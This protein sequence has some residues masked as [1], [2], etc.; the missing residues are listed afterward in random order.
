M[1]IMFLADGYHGIISRLL[2]ESSGI[3]YFAHMLSPNP[4]LINRD[5]DEEVWEGIRKVY[6]QGILERCHLACITSLARADRW[7]QSVRVEMASGNVLGFSAALRGFLE[8]AAD[9]HDVMKI[10]PT[11]IHKLFPYLYLVFS[12]SVEVKNI[13]LLMGELEDGLIHYAYARRLHKGEEHLPHHGHKSNADYIEKFET[14]GVPGAK[15]LYAELCELTHPASSSVSCFYRESEDSIV[16]DFNR[17][18]EIIKGILTR[19]DET[20]ERLVQFSINPALI[21]LSYLHRLFDEWPGPADEEV[22]RL[23]T[24][25][26]RLSEID[27]FVSAYKLGQVDHVMLQKALT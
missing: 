12:D 27:G 4:E 5:M 24:V 17:D 22:G 11:S 2:A 15:N 19:F 9:S 13:N 14:F 25:E 26:Q 18:T 1:R 8:A 23:G 3:S 20:V 7:L 21:G 10:L 6:T 16:L